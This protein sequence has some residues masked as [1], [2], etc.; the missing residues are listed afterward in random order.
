MDE[1]TI[2]SVTGRKHPGH[3]ATGHESYRRS[4]GG[5]H[6]GTQDEPAGFRKL[7]PAADA[8]F[9]ASILVAELLLQIELL[10][11]DDALLNRDHERY[12]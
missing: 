12:C 1:A 6:P 5:Q 3:P 9:V 8:V 10:G 11:E 2:E 7:Q 4:E